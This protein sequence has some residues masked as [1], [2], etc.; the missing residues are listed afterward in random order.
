[1]RK[2]GEEVDVD[3]EEAL[4]HEES[5]DETVLSVEN[6]EVVEVIVELDCEHQSHCHEFAAVGEDHGR[7][8]EVILQVVQVQIR[9][10]YESGLVRGVGRLG[11]WGSW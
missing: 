5:P 3:D 1:M 11:F 6:G 9:E 10:H 2:I 8:E 4:L 7:E